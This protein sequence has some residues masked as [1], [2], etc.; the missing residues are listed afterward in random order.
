[1]MTLYRAISYEE[2]QNTD[3]STTGDEVDIIVGMVQDGILTPV[4][5]C[6]HGRYDRH[7][8]M[9]K[10]PWAATVGGNPC[11]GAG[12]EDTE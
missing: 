2:A 11:L 10:L 1:M 5:K 6:K 7:W 12:L 3:W 9:N 8:V 4:E